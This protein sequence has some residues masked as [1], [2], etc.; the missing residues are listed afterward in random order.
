MKQIDC[1]RI[2]VS[3]DERNH[4]LFGYFFDEELGLKLSKGKGWY[5]TDGTST[6]VQL[7]IFST[8]EEYEQFYWKKDELSALEKFNTR[9]TPTEKEAL[10]NYLKEL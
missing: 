3:T 2:D 4:K 6:Q 1:F 8:E 9:F 10:K 5:G 7:T